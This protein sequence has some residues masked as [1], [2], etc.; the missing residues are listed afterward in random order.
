MYAVVCPM[1]NEDDRIRNLLAANCAVDAFVRRWGDIEESRARSLVEKV[2]EDITS[3]GRPPLMSMV[4]ILYL[5]MLYESEYDDKN[6]EPRG[7]RG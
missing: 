2:Y 5:K 3:Q 4:E 1:P 6:P 7:G